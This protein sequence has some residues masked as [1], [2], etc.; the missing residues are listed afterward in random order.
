MCTK[1][2]RV[3]DAQLKPDTVIGIHLDATQKPVRE[4]SSSD[5]SGV[6]KLRVSIESS[7][8][9]ERAS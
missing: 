3:A 7:S 6:P 1:Q 2:A 4:T 9:N 5:S 8:Q